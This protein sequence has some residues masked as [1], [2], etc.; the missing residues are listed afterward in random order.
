MS[1]LY[2][3]VCPDSSEIFLGIF[4]DYAQA[5]KRAENFLENKRNILT[6]NI[7]LSKLDS[8][9]SN[10]DL[11]TTVGVTKAKKPVPVPRRVL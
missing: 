5:R 1:S 10:R 3:V 6:V 2:T 7:Y 4:S 8:K 9:G 11:L